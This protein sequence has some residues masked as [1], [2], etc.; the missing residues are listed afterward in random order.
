[1]SET[2]IKIAIQKSG[3]LTEHSTTLLQKCGL[4]FSQAKNQLIGYG[5]N[6]PIDL[7]FVRDDDIPDLIQENLCSLGI[8]GKNVALEKKI[9]MDNSKQGCLFSFEENLN[10]GQC[11]L[12]FA[13][14]ESSSYR[15]IY[16]LEGKTIATSYPNIVKKFLKE[17]G[18]NVYVTQ[19]S[20]AVELAP[21]LGKAEA[22]CDLV[23]TGNTLKVHNLIQGE[24]VL[25]SVA[26]V[27]RSTQVLSDSKEAWIKKLIERIN[28]VIQVSE[29]KY[30]M[31]H[32][33]KDSLQKITELLPGTEA[34]TVLPLEGTNTTVAVHVVCKETVFWETLEGLKKIGASSILV[35]PLEKMLM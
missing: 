30:I 1:M 8:V 4:I 22:I 12:T 13:Y 34:P 11:R 2:R 25:D 18:L 33:P 29:S 7:M 32:A 19:F 6:M 27:L 24:V 28:G 17:K 9:A 21:S 26:T 16:D 23:S 14:P 15:S 3:R 31:M 20:G 10:F 35:V 5:E